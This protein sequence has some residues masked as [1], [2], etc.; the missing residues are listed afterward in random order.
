MSVVLS[1]ASV[2]T[3]DRLA[4]WHEVIS[5]TYEQLASVRLDISNLA[6]APYT[7]MIAAGRIGPLA[8]ASTIA[9]P[10]H[11]RKPRR[12]ELTDDDC[13]NVC[14]QEHGHLGCSRVGVTRGLEGP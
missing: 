7:G 10:L 3:A 1:T 14:I 13:V 5:Q 6:N 12:G 11:V 2:P 4:Y 8:V 9:D